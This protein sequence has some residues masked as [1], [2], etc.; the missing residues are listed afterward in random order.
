MI[1][2]AL[3]VLSIFTAS[4]TGSRESASPNFAVAVAKTDSVARKIKP[5]CLVATDWAVANR[6]TLPR[7]LHGFSELSLVYRKAAYWT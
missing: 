6:L 5:P 4:S 7:T 1:A 2:K 3:I